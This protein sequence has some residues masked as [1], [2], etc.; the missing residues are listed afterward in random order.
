MPEWTLGQYAT[1]KLGVILVNINPAYR[2]HELQ[3]VLNQAGIA[4]L[5]AATSFKTS[6]YAAMIEEVRPNC[7]ALRQVVLLGTPDWDALV[8]A[9]KRGDRAELA[10]RQ[11]DLSPDDPI[12]IQYTSGTTG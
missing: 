4:V 6:D 1:A 11:A 12:N 3:F 7:P 8:E 10:Q 2:T 9:G 5:V